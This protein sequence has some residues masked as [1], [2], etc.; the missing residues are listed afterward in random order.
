MDHDLPHNYEE[1]FC[2]QLTAA[3]FTI[4]NTLSILLK[5]LNKI[6]RGKFDGKYR[7]CHCTKQCDS[8]SFGGD[9]VLNSFNMEYSDEDSI[10]DQKLKTNL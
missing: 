6:S 3:L 1:Q 10:L 9:V 5:D 7:Y 2:T 4:V 8:N